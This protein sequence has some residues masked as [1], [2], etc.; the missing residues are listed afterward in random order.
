MYLLDS[1]ESKIYDT[2]KPPT[3]ALTII[4]SNKIKNYFYRDS[5]NEIDGVNII[6]NLNGKRILIFY[7]PTGTIRKIMLWIPDEKWG[8]ITTEYY[9]KEQNIFYI[10]GIVLSNTDL[11]NIKILATEEYENA[12]IALRNKKQVQKNYHDSIENLFKDQI[13]NN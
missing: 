1:I 2:T 4:D 3:F 10:N 11:K 6:F 12:K 5:I 7:T 9:F 8:E 13:K